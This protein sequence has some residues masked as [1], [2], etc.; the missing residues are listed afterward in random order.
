MQPG[1]LCRIYAGSMDEE[2]VES[3]FLF[4][5]WFFPS[6]FLSF[7]FHPQKHQ[8]YLVSLLTVFHPLRQCNT[9]YGI[10]MNNVPFLW[11]S[12]VKI[13][14]PSTASQSLIMVAGCIGLAINS[15]ESVN[16]NESL[17]YCC[18][19]QIVLNSYEQA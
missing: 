19:K 15:T 8:F 4:V 12:Q 14:S 16:W 2:L 11:Q 6:I 18:F 5:L 13:H 7:T 17:H 1:S 10:M 9:L 3:F